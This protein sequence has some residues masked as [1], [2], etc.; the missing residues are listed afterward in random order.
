MSVRNTAHAERVL[1]NL[2]SAQWP[3]AA[4][5]ATLRTSN[6]RELAAM[7]RRA[8]HHIASL[9]LVEGLPP[10]VAR[11]ALAFSNEVKALLRRTEGKR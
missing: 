4:P 5:T 11:T 10:E 7:L 9:A 1:S 3:I 2:E 8:Q 6:E